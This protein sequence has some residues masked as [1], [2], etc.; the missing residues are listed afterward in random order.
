MG[1]LNIKYAKTCPCM[2]VRWEV[3]YN[4]HGVA[5][6]SFEWTIMAISLINIAGVLS[7]VGW[8]FG[9]SGWGEFVTQKCSGSIVQYLI[10]MGFFVS[11]STAVNAWQSHSYNVQLPFSP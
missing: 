11:T 8:G 5:K 6:V 1:Y 4:L 9:W 3:A 2:S 10:Y 7:G